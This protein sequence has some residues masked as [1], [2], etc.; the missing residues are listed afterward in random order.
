MNDEEDLEAGFMGS[1]GAVLIA[2]TIA[3]YYI[4]RRSLG[5]A[6]ARSRLFTYA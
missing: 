1:S 6:R 3:D 4:L 2:L 5:G